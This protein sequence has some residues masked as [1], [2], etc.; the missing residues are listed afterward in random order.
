MSSFNLQK[1]LMPIGRDNG[2][3]MEDYWV[4]DGSIIEGE[5]GRWHM[6]ASRWPKKYRMHPG[7]LFL[8]EIVRAS[9][10][11]PEGPYAFE[12][13]VLA[14]RDP[15]YFDGQMTH[16]PSIRKCGDR[17]LLFYI[18]VSYGVPFPEDPAECPR[19]GVGETDRWCREVWLR[20]RIGMAWSKS[21]FGPW[22]RVDEPILKPR[23]G[24]WDRGTTS[25]PSPFVM[26][27]G[28]IYLAY[29]SG[30]CPEGT[31]L[32][33]FRIGLAR[34]EAWDAPF[35]R[36]L[37][38]PILQPENPGTFLEDPFLWYA[39]GQF[40]IMMKELQGYESGHKGYGLYASSKD[41]RNWEWGDPITAYTRELPFKDGREEVGQVERP[42]LVFQNGKATHF[43][44]ASAYSAGDLQEVTDS[45]V[46]VIPLGD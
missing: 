34:A 41:G 7:W 44:A 36:V 30:F 24:E 2:F 33:P 31:N 40:H 37:D 1:K 39:E 45:W 18:G 29:K 3:R 20:K 46:S 4:W 23:P 15:C 21:V 6:F 13:V 35:E 17:Y 22:E 11:T 10:D 28:S 26:E 19:E 43:T 8:S 25:N 12:E 27:D 5:D 16:N 9:S 42:Q 38:D 14:R 32:Q